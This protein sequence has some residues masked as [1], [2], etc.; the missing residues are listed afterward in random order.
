MAIVNTTTRPTRV[1]L[2]DNGK[3]GK[4]HIIDAILFSFDLKTPVAANTT[5]I[6]AAVTGNASTAVTTT[7]PQ[8][9]Y[10]L[11]VPR[12]ITVTSGGTA[13]SIAATA[14]VVTG[15]NLEGKVI[16]ESLTPVAGTA[17]TLS[18]TKVFAVVTSFVVPI[19]SGAGATFSVGTG[20]NFGIGG[21]NL[22]VTQVKLFK[23]PVGTSS[24]DKTQTLVNA[25]S[26]NFDSSLVENNW[27]TLDVTPSGAF[28]Y[29]VYAFNYNWH[30]NPVNDLT[31][32]IQSYGV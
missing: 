1:T 6:S 22:S 5:L 12:S 18:G 27:V 17:G 11:D 9:G 16:T 19:Q 2:G 25:A 7:L 28:R 14:V 4:K 8:G 20:L 26:T 24:T 21:R 32:G 15:L 10:V 23:A 3:F 30:L 29:R 31:K 13:A